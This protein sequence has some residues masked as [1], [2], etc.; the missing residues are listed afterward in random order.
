[1][2]PATKKCVDLLSYLRDNVLVNNLDIINEINATVEA[3]ADEDA[4]GA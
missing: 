2:T 3:V 1:M 4:A